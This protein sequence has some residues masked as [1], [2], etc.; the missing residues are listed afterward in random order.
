MYRLDNDKYVHSIYIYIYIVC[1]CV[2]VCVIICLRNLEQV[3]LRDGDVERERELNLSWPGKA[4]RL[5]KYGALYLRKE[6]GSVVTWGDPSCGGDSSTVASRSISDGVWK[7][8]G[9]Q[10]LRS[11]RSFISF[12]LLW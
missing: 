1:V 9:T 5:L 7:W 3:N 10:V 4:Q 2:C 8:T 6:D 11:Q 12:S